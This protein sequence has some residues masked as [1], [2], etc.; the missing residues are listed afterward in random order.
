MKH[1]QTISNFASVCA[2]SVLLLLLLLQM[3]DAFRIKQQIKGNNNVALH[4]FFYIYLSL[5]FFLSFSLAH[6][7]CLPSI[8]AVACYQ[9]MWLITKY[10]RQ[11]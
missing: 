1:K 11:C 9:E 6:S 7:N 3:Q 2:L 4:C 8:V 10:Q 5:S